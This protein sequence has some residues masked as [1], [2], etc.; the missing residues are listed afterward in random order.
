MSTMKNRMF[1]ALISVLCVLSLVAG[2]APH[3]SYA[4]N[5]K[6][7]TLICRSD[8]VTL[9]GMRWKLYRVGERSGDE[10][11]F[12]GD[13]ADYPVS[14]GDMT[15]ESVNAAAKT[16]ESYAVADGI[17]PL[18][19]GK[20][21]SNGEKLFDSLGAGL[22]LAT[23]KVL[24]VGNVYYVPSALLIEI[25]DEGAVF[26]YDAYPKFWY[27]TLGSEVIAYTV[28][29]VWVD[30]DAAS[31]AR[32]VN[33]TVDLYKDETLEDTVVL[34]DSNDWEYRWVELADGYEWHVVE[35]NIPVDYEVSI[36]FNETQYLIKNSYVG[37]S[38]TTTTTTVITTTSGTGSSVE[39][40]STNVAKTTSTT[41]AAPPP[42]TT[43]ASGGGK[44]PQTGQL[45][46][47]VIPLSIGGVLMIVVG[48]MVRPKRKADAE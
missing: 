19:Q 42:P 20:T 36:D 10:F 29:K 30:D 1:A 15:E 28:K 31:Q 40:T 7:L 46:W 37:A 34:D 21:D 11:V 18:A 27:A 41:T 24:Q 9:A 5:N 47:P 25:T 12:T 44:I 17:A 35:R 14:L 45:W 33:V 26:D 38:T 8:D 48:F 22:Y 3:D 13:F 4:E 2:F 16:L 6:T 32:P 39:T 23:G 43:T